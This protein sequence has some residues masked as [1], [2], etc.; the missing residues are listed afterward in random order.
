MA[1]SKQDSLES[2][3]SC[4]NRT[5]HGRWMSEEYI[6]G[7]VSVIIPTYNRAKYL[8]EAMDSVWNQTY[9]PI[10]L[11]VVDDG[12]TDGT[13][14]ILEDWKKKLAGDRDF[15]L[16]YFYQTNKGANFARNLG[17]RHSRGEFI[18][19][20]D[21]DDILDS[22]RIELQAKRL[23]NEA[24]DMC[25]GSFMS[26]PDRKSNYGCPRHSDDVMLD[27]L[28]W[29]VHGG[30]LCWM[31]RRNLIN[32]VGGYNENLICYQDID[33]TFRLLAMSP[34]VAFQPEALTFFHIHDGPC[35]S[36][37]K[38][39]KEGMLSILQSHKNRVNMLKNSFNNQRYLDAEN[40]EI[41]RFAIHAYARGF[42]EI[43]QDFKNLSKQLNSYSLPG[44]T[45]AM[46]MFLKICGVE[47]CGLAMRLLKKV[48][49]LRFAECKNRSRN[50]SIIITSRTGLPR[51]SK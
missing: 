27:F 19:F 28:K 4:A 29:R 49:K 26:F 15:E 21:S 40:Q 48:N 10:E 42:Y 18:L 32:A 8:V 23:V 22:R 50:K 9:R 7:I 35:V 37:L 16:R 13:K 33:L 25:S 51:D 12:S 6:P 1:D 24:A 44:S 31:I 41:L 34:K 17:L 36:S 11:I 30:T 2:M 47:G 45:W 20:H 43:S 14:E 5:C 38:S 46:R 3:E 39:A